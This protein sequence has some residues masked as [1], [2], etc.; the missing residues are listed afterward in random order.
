MHARTTGDTRK[1]WT[2]LSEQLDVR[3]LVKNLENWD[4]R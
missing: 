2:I 1:N 3:M 4:H